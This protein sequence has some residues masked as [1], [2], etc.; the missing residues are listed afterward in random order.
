MTISAIQLRHIETAISAKVVATD[1][2]SLKAKLVKLQSAVKS[3][4]NLSFLTD[5][6]LDLLFEVVTSDLGECMSNLE[7]IG[8]PITEQGVA[9][10]ARLSAKVNSIEEFITV[11]AGGTDESLE[12]H[13]N[14]ER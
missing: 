5:E 2:P 9:L 10:V 1:E 13:L 14:I 7:D 4:N 3:A 12:N 8:T 6:A 11:L